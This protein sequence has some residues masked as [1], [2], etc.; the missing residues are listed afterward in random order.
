M[1]RKPKIKETLASV[2]INVYGIQDAIIKQNKIAKEQLEFEK[3]K[4]E[5]E[6]KNKDRVDISLKRYEEMK[7]QIETLKEQNEKYRNIF[8]RMGVE[9]WANDIE[10]STI[11]V[12][13]MK[14]PIRLSTRVHIQFESKKFNDFY[15]WI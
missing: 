13:T 9:E 2:D 5:F 7:S 6:T 3:N 10:P 11:Q 14:D 1:K 15:G 4:F 12:A 8:E